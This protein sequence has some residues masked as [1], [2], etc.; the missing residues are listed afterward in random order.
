MR[1]VSCVISAE[2][3]TPYI[4]SAC[5]SFCFSCTNF[6]TTL[7][8]DSSLL[9]EKLWYGRVFPVYCPFFRCLYCRSSHAG[10]IWN[11]VIKVASSAVVVRRLSCCWYCLSTVFPFER[12]GNDER[13][14]VF[15]RRSLTGV[16]LLIFVSNYRHFCGPN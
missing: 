12:I 7:F 5:S 16:V 1:F 2:F 9:L 14:F 4:F 10:K 6:R 15:Q 3:Q 13:F 11:A 8:G